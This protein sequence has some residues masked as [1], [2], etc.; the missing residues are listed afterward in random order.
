MSTSLSAI[1]GVANR[2]AAADAANSVIRFIWGPPPEGFY[3]LLLI[4]D[5]Y[6]AAAIASV[7]RSELVR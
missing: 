2:T 1:A 4:I 5:S 3:Q 7:G 6:W